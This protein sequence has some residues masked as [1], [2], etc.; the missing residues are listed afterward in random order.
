VTPPD[1]HVGDDGAD[2]NIAVHTASG[3][4]WKASTDADWIRLKGETSQTGSGDVK[5]RVER[6]HKKAQRIGVIQVAGTRVV[7][8]QDG[9]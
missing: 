6:N 7:V 2:E 5:F 9:H 1:V 8:T 3:C 4:R